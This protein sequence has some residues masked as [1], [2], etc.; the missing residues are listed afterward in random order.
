[1]NK[2]SKILLTFVIILV[3][4]LIIMTILFFKMKNLAYYNYTMYESQKNLSNYLEK[5]LEE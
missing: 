5:R 4:S 1:M 3:I 2:L